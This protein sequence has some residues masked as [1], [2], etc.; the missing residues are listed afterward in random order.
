MYFFRC[1]T[2]DGFTGII[3]I[4]DFHFNNGI[5]IYREGEV[6]IHHIF[7]KVRKNHKSLIFF[8]EASVNHI[9]ANIRHSHIYNLKPLSFGSSPLNWWK[10]WRRHHLCFK[11]FASISMRPSLVKAAPNYMKPLGN[12]EVEVKHLILWRGYGMDH[13]P[14]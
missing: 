12:G 4:Q 5:M 9:C 10:S 8:K 6:S 2:N 13:H 3:E 1:L 7:L 14:W 11:D